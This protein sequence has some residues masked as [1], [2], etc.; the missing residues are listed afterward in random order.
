MHIAI[1]STNKVKVQAVEEVVQH[2]PMLAGATFFSYPVSSEVPEQPNGLAEIIQGAKN[3]AK[4]AFAAC[5]G[6]NYSFGMESGIFEAPGSQ[7]GFLEATICCIYDGSHDYIGLSCGFE[8]PPSILEHILHRDM[9][10]NQACYH[11]GL[12]SNASLG[13]AEGMIGLLTKGRI[14]RKE[15]TKQ[16]VMTALIQLE[17]NALYKSKA[18]S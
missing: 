18:E 17:N 3:R 16:C 8:I 10:L 5:V 14:T 12:S 6:C 9:D 1:G 15:Y 13:S 11:S 2:Y 7:T 4:H